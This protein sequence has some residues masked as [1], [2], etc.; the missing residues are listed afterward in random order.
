MNVNSITSHIRKKIP[1]S[2]KSA[3]ILG[4]GLGNFVDSLEKPIFIP[5]SEISGHPCSTVSGHKG[6]WVF[7]YIKNKPIICASGRFHLY[8]GFKLD[9][10]TLPISVIYSLGCQNVFITNSAGCLKQN[11]KIGNFMLISG[12]LDNTYLNGSDPSSIVMFNKEQIHKNIKNKAAKLGISLR[13][14]IYTG[15]L[16]PSFETPAEI[17]DIIALGGNAV[18]MSTLHELMKAIELGLKIVG[19]SCLTNYGAG[20]EGSVLSHKDVLETSS[21][22]KEDFSLLLTEIV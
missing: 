14:G 12:Y 8:E 16:G 18:G 19:L 2:P 13:E 6:E 20:M 11:W 10:V 1:E 7:G 21:R 22:V 5:Y 4:S 15:V 9:E 3:V 17:Q